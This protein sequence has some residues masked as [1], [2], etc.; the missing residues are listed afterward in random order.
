MA[1]KPSVCEWEVSSLPHAAALEGLSYLHGC[2]ILHLDVKPENLLMTSSDQLRLC[3]FGNAQRLAPEGAQYCKYGTPEFVGPEIVSQSPVS[4]VTDVWPVGVIAYLWPDG[5]LPFVGENDKTTLLNIRNY[6]VA[7]EESMFLGLTREAKGFL[8]KVLVNDRLETHAEQTLEHL[9]LRTLAKGKSISTDHLKL[10]ICRRKC[11]PPDQLQRQPGAESHPELLEDTS[12]HLSIAVPRHLKDSP[13]LSSSSDSEELDEL[14][15]LPMPRQVEFSGSR[16]SSTRSPRRTTPWARP[17]GRWRRRPP[18]SGRRRARGEAEGRQPAEEAPGGGGPGSSDEDSAE[19]RPRPA[20]PGKALKK[21]PSLESPEGGRPAGRRGGLQRGSSA[22]SA[23]LLGLPA[24][25]GAGPAGQGPPTALRKAASM[26]LPRRSPSPGGAPRRQAEEEGG[27]RLLRGSP[28]EPKV[29]GL[30]GPLLETLEKKVPRPPGQQSSRPRGPGWCG[31]PPARRP[32][33]TR[34]RAA[35]AAEERLPSA[36]GTWSRP[37]AQGVPLA[38]RPDRVPAPDPR[39]SS[40]KPPIPELPEAPLSRGGCRRTLPDPEPAWQLWARSPPP[41]SLKKSPPAHGRQ[42]P[43]PPRSPCRRPPSLERP[44]RSPRALDS[45]PPSPP[46]MH[47]SFSPSS[48]R[49]ARAACPARASPRGPPRPRCGGARGGGARGG[50]LQQRPGHRGH[51]LGGSLRGQVQAGPGVFAQPRPEAPHQAHA[52]GRPLASP[53]VREEGMYRPGPA[54]APLELSKGPAQRARSVQDLREPEEASF[55]RRMSQRLWRTPPMERKKP[56]EEESGREPPSR[57]RV[58]LEPGSGQLQGQAGLGEPEIGARQERGVGRSPPAGHPASRPSWPCGGRSA[59]PWSASPSACAAPRTQ[60]AGRGAPGSGAR[61]WPCCGG[62]TRRGEPAQ[63]GDPAEPAGGAVCPGASAESFQSE[64]STQEVG[65]QRGPETL[66]VGPLG[67]VP[68][69]EDK[70]ASQPNI[71]A[72]LLQEDGTIVGRQY[73]RHESD[74]SPVF[75]IKLKDQVLL[76]GD[77][78]TLFCLP[79]ASPSP[80]ILWMKDKQ[81]LVSDA[82]VNIVSCKDGRQLLTIPKTCKKDAGLYECTAANALGTATSSCTLAV[83]RLPGKPGTPEI[84]QKYKNTV[85]VLWKPADSC[86]PCTYTL[87]CK[88][89]GE[90]EW[91]TIGSGIADC[92]FNVTELPARSTA[93]FRVACSNK[94]GQGPYSNPSETVAIE[95]DDPSAAHSAPAARKDAAAP[96]RAA[97]S[98]SPQT[99]PPQPAP[100]T[101]GAPPPTPPRKHKGVVHM[102]GRAPQPAVP[103]AVSAAVQPP[104]RAE[105]D[106]APLGPLCPPAAP[107]SSPAPAAPPAMAVSGSPEL[108]LTPSRTAPPPPLAAHTTSQAVRGSPAPPAQPPARL[109]PIPPASVP[110]VSPS[111]KTAPMY[112]VTSFV[113]MPAVTPPMEAPSPLLNEAAATRSLVQS[114]APSRE[115]GGPPSRL[116]PTGQGAPGAKE[117]TTLRQGVPQ[118]PYT[119]LEEKARGRFGVIRECK[120]NATGKHFM[121]KIIPYEAEKKQSVLQEYEILKGLHHERV[122]AL[123]EAYI[124]P[125]YLV[126]I[127]ENCAGKEILY[128]LIDRFRF[129]EDDVAGYVLQLLQGLQY[130]HGRRVLHLDLKPDNV[131]VAHGNAVKI[132]DFGSAQSYDPRG[133]RRLGR[134]VGTLECMSPEMV[135]GDP[136][137]SAAD[138]W[139]VG[140]L[141]FI[142]LSGRS[143]FFELDPIETENRILAGRFDAFKLYPNVSQSAAL[144]IRKLLCIYP[145]SRPTVQDCFANPWLQDAYLM[146]LRRQTLTFTTN[147]LKEFLVEHQRRRGEAAT[148][149]KVLL[150][151]YHGSGGQPPPGPVTQ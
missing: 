73:L 93:R 140:V 33:S 101:A 114:A 106:A 126:L 16:V 127:A 39:E 119:F 8:I 136:V 113:S 135:K 40:S 63:G 123:H 110:P 117:G 25:D 10:F 41:R 79:A 147:R 55:I 38:L 92:Y 151:S 137:G 58:S 13:A 74:F 19:A 94:A 67:P 26:E 36:R 18:W 72:S 42:L 149:H 143:P 131:L 146:K 125:R 52:E 32:R 5:D 86:A 23:L 80:K 43:E 132:V 116:S 128:S 69:Q 6:N 35:P 1:R 51:R 96:E 109:A 11:A 111:P 99:A 83:A 22:D 139:G 56:E 76:E 53:L 121:A 148:K 66:P 17:R 28:V 120:E 34:P 62:P 88:L 85:L 59:P 118:K 31:R 115:P 46:P 21:G 108:G 82:A 15:L 54:G 7:F 77:P 122:M 14:P 12:S 87:E 4:I 130:L 144:F 64:S 104:P 81:S 20:G 97:S 84:P 27:Q 3:D 9:G 44:C 90:R 24:E 133:L 141:T 57:G 138:I 61:C 112:M 2:S 150:R 48:C 105:A 50:A 100:Q 129:S 30:R 89:N 145:W 71:P 68:R 91:K 103:R 70:V 37:A 98:R 95:T 107:A 29:S 78:A 65:S 49:S 45:R 60:G 134:R 47:K 124:T 102:P 75:H 142:M